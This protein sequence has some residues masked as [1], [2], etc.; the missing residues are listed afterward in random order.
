ML[1]IAEPVTSPVPTACYEPQTAAVEGYPKVQIPQ[2]IGRS[3]SILRVY[4]SGSMTTIYYHY[5]TGILII[6]VT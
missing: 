6:A 3:I 4:K 1:R 2:K 5:S